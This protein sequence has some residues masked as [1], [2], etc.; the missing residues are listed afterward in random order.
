MSPPIDFSGKRKEKQI[1]KW[2]KNAGDFIASRA[3]GPYS[4]QKKKKGH[5]AK[6]EKKIIQQ[7]R[8]LQRKKSQKKRTSD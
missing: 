6:A 5:L 8:S 7:A 4:D 1:Q 2:R 3:S